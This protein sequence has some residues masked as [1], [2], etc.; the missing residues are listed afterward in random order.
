V[1]GLTAL[2]AA[3]RLWRLAE[4]PPGLHVDEAYNILDARA[5][6]AG[7]RP[8]FLPA[9]AGREVLYTYWQAGLIGLLG[10]SIATARLA[11]AIA[12]SLLVPAAWW[13]AR[14]LLADS[15]Q[16]ADRVRR[17]A[18][19]VAALTTFSYWHL[20]FSR[21][22]IRA[23]LFPLAVTVTLGAWWMAVRAPRPPAPSPVEPARGRRRWAVV[24]LAAGLGLA[25][26]A[27]PVGRVLFVVPA[28]HALYRWLRWR[29]IEAAKVLGV[30]MVGAVI[31]ALPLLAFWARQPWLLTGHVDEVSILRRGTGA[32][33][34][35]VARVA[36]M[37]NLAGDPARW[38]NLPGRPVFDPLT[39]LLFL[40]GLAMALRAAWR[41]ADWAALA[42][43]WLGLLLVPTALTDQAPSFSRAIGVLP[44]VFLFPALGLDGLVEWASQ[45]VRPAVAVGL[46]VGLL[47]IG[48]VWT[49]GDYFVAW[50]EHPDTPLAFDADK[51][52]LGYTYRQRTAA[53][54]FV[55]LTEAMAGHPTVVV[56]AGEAPAGFDPA[57]GWVMPASERRIAEYA[58]LTIEQAAAEALRQTLGPFLTPVDAGSGEPR[59][60]V[61]RLDPAAIRSMAPMARPGEATFGQAIALARSPDMASALAAG[62][63]AAVGLL[64]RSISPA[65]QPLHTAVQLVSPA[66]RLIGQGD[67]PPLGGS[68]PTNRWRPDELVF[69]RHPMAVSADAPRGPVDLR[70]GWYVP[71]ADGQPLEPVLTEDGQTL[72]TV[73]HTEVRR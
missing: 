26:Y 66:G 71:P 62:T 43:L 41:G 64:W 1:V 53:G 58:F 70:V 14:L 32:V 44:I 38:R 55:Y 60:L 28:A 57:Q 40:G 21:Y 17:T 59:P 7:W 34:T 36:G 72:V 18:L 63:T 15:G 67:G 23:V 10:E 47:V 29:D 51:V 39:G 13:L 5:V 6:L 2:A 52:A 69:S 61:L 8:L 20:H 25:V 24:V 27:H 33:A 30:A 68:Y 48:G 3:L 56:A 73:G 54:A 49:V 22:G 42:L 45:W 11:S 12:G 9:N 37:F 19:F 46:A 65:D 50:A 35:N 4:L 31:V 16:G